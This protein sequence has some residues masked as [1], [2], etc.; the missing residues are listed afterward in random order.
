LIICDTSAW[1]DHLRDS[2]TPAAIRLDSLVDTD[3]VVVTDGVVLEL[4]A[5]ARDDRHLRDLERML[6]RF[7]RVATEQD[8]FEEAASIYRWCR[9]RGATPRSL[10]DCVIAAVAIRVGASVLHNDRDFDT[11]A[12]HV[13]LLIDGR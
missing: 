10:L 8:D 9:R 7:G 12:E 5:G 6:A 2:G 11:I 13:S 1:I 3:E 4:L